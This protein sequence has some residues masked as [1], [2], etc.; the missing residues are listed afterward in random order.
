MRTVFK[1]NI[2]CCKTAMN[3][4]PREMS[5]IPAIGTKFRLPCPVRAP[6]RM[7]DKTIQALEMDVVEVIFVYHSPYYDNE[8]EMCAEIELHHKQAHALGLI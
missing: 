5:I 3:E 6:N 1:T 4:M 8:K 7:G 2:D